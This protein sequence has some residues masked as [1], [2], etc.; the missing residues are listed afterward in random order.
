MQ[1]QPLVQ[2]TMTINPRDYFV[3]RPRDAKKAPSPITVR[4]GSI[5]PGRLLPGRAALNMLSL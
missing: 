3:K 4:F 2:E 1:Q 5:L